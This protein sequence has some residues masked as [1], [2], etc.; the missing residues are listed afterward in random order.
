MEL[1]VSFPRLIRAENVDTQVIELLV[2]LVVL[3]ISFLRSQGANPDGNQ[4]VFGL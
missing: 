2:E 4:G 1:Q 3:N